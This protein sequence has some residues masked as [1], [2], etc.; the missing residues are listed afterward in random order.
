MYGQPSN[1]AELVGVF[2]DILSL[3]IPFI[4]GLSLLIIIWKVV[5]AWVIN[6]GD[7]D[8]IEEGR[9]VA[10]WGII[11]LVIM[12]GIWAILRILRSSIFGG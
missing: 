7:A 3:I 8:K 5:D 1:F 6:G 9:N 4:F 12:S 11:V 2:I 10:L